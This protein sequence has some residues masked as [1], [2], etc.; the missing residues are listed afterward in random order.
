MESK[1]VFIS[2]CS[3]RELA[4]RRPSRRALWLQSNLA[5]IVLVVGVVAFVI[6]RMGA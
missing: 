3:R 6:A 4:R 2:S 1:T 5:M